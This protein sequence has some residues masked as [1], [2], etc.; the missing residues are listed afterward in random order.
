V[1]IYLDWLHWIDIG[2]SK[3]MLVLAADDNEIESN[4]SNISID[5]VSSINDRT[6]DRVYDMIY[7]PFISKT[8]EEAVCFSLIKECIGLLADD[9]II[10]V[11]KQFGSKILSKIYMRIFGNINIYKQ[12]KDYHGF[13]KIVI[14]KILELENI[15]KIK[16]LFCFPS[17]F[18]ALTISDTANLLI[19]TR[20]NKT[21]TYKNII[22]IYILTS[23]LFIYLAKYFWRDKLVLL[24]KS[25]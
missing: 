19:N 2:S 17:I 4:F 3:S 24:R 10:V 16:E 1:I 18:S 14:A 12:Y 25:E 9:G 7:I 6:P 15:E 13:N 5:L 22:P 8:E 11:S 23:K 20:F 21:K